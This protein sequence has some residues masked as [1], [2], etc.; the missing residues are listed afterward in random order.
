MSK[1]N[2]T[3]LI[4]AGPTA[5]GKT[6]LCINL[7]KKFHT[8]IV[9]ADSRQFFKEMNIGTA[10]PS[11]Q[12]RDIV[13]HY[14][15]DNLSIMDNYDVARYEKE[16]LTLLKSLFSTQDMAI[17][18][19]GS[20][21]YI[22]ALTKGLDD[23]PAVDDAIR[24]AL[25]ERYKREGI[26]FLQEKLK[27]LD[28]AYFERVD[29]GNPQRLI[30]ALEV[31]IGTGRPFSSFR[32]MTKADRPFGCIKIGLERDRQE[33]YERINSRMDDMIAE[34][35]FEEA[36]NLF[37]MRRHNALQTVGYKEIFGYLEGHYDKEEAIRL[38][39]RNSRRYAKR[40]MTWFRRDREYHWFHP[41]QI[42]EI[43]GFIND[44][45]GL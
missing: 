14:F 17:L 5:V 8:P 37:P 15:V 3:L 29:T 36:A 24:D 45:M 28:P 35:L 12:E 20:G 22:E 32:K 39:K 27:I 11:K 33:L 42:Q 25:N 10:K 26:S 18:T 1:K 40:Q 4:I 34:G 23:I 38:L 44:Q 2:K 41:S 31:S 16:A 9:S 13:K 7:A 21:L 6:D 19:G 43:I 30:R